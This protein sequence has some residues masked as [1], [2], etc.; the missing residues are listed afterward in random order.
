MTLEDAGAFDGPD[1]TFATAPAAAGKKP[2]LSLIHPLPA[3]AVQG[4]KVVAMGSLGGAQV[5]FHAE[6]IK[7]LPGQRVHVRYLSDSAGNTARI[8]LPMIPTAYVGADELLS[9]TPPADSAP[10]EAG[11]SPPA[12]PAT[13]TGLLGRALAL[14]RQN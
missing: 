13:S 6:V 3:Y 7:V 8:C 1:G 2:R 14:F 5:P 4:A 11:E 9:G 10:V 12:A